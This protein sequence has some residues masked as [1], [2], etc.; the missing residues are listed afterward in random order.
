MTGDLGDSDAWMG[1][2]SRLIAQILGAAL[3]LLVMTEGG[4]LGPAY[5]AEEM[6]A[7]DMWTV[8]GSLAGGALLW[9]VYDRCDAWVAAIG[10]MALS[11]ALALGGASDMGAMLLNMGDADLV[12]S[13]ANWVLNGAFA[14]VGALAS[15]KL[16]SIC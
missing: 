14:G 4:D 13:L 2:G 1:N 12:A 9:T 6:W 7:F 5:V 10:V 15:V 3:A 11:G 8:V 16:A